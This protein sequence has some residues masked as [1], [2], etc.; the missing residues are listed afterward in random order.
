MLLVRFV[1]GSVAWYGFGWLYLRAS[2]TVSTMAGNT[3]SC[4]RPELDENHVTY[5]SN[6]C[7]SPFVP[8]AVLGP[9]LRGTVPPSSDERFSVPSE[10]QM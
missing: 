8:L 10:G 9:V 2:I 4:C 6:W 3:G 1:A 7:R 5:T